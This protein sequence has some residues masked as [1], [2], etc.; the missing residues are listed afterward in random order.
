MKHLDKYTAEDKTID[1]G[2]FSDMYKEINGFRP[3][4]HE[5][6]T[7]TQER[8][9]EIREGLN[10]AHGYTRDCGFDFVVGG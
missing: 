8:R 2:R 7:A 6:F 5:Y 1:D 9:R 3:R 4:N 10:R